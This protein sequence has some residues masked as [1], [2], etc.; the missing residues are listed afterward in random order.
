M[1]TWDIPS[2]IIRSHPLCIFGCTCPLVSVSTHLAV[3]LLDQ[4]I[5]TI[6]CR[7]YCQRMFSSGVQN[8]FSVTDGTLRSPEKKG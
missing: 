3:E 8:P 4:S 6:G 2:F 5:H 7:R 1:D